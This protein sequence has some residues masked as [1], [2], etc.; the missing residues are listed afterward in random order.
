[1]QTSPSQVVY[2]RETPLFVQ[3]TQLSVA[4][5]DSHVSK[6]LG[7]VQAKRRQNQWGGGIFQEAAPIPSHPPCR[8][9]I[10]GAVPSVSHGST[11]PTWSLAAIPCFL[12]S[13]PTARQTCGR[14][15]SGIDPYR[16]WTNVGILNTF[17]PLFRVPQQGTLRRKRA[18]E[19]P[20]VRG[21]RTV[22]LSVRTLLIGLEHPNSNIEVAL[23]PGP[24]GLMLDAKFAVRPRHHLSLFLSLG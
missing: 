23:T 14:A 4:E 20:L 3:A 6:G 11:P 19:D 18:P 10:H 22:T 13:T 17:V 16:V 2:E 21:G 24:G 8:A 5:T 12:L 7:Q 9:E 1:M 15:K